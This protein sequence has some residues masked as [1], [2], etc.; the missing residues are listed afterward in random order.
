MWAVHVLG[1]SDCVL[2]STAPPT[3]S[4]RTARVTLLRSVQDLVQGTG[5]WG[6]R[7]WGVFFSFL[8]PFPLSHL[9]LFFS[10]LLCQGPEGQGLGTQP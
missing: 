6:A 8:F 4:G 9:S 3:P 2:Y 1:P 7:V 5:L 10:F